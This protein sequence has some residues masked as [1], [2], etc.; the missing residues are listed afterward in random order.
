MLPGTT[1]SS[2]TSSSSP[3]CSPRATLLD[4]VSRDRR[5]RRPRTQQKIEFYTRQFVD[6]MAP[7]QLR[8]DQSRG[9]ARDPREPAART[10]SAASSNM[11]EDLERGNGQLS[12]RMT[13]LDAFEVGHNIATTP[14]KVVYQNELMQLIQYAP[15]HR[16]GAQAAAADRAALDQQVLHPRPAAQEQ[17]HQVRRRPGLHRLRD[18][19]GQ[20]RRGAQPQDLRGL[21]GGGPARGARRHRAGDRRDGRQRDRLLPRRHA[22]GRRRWPIMAA[23]K[24]NRDQGGDLLHHAARL[25]RSGRARRVHR[26][27]AAG[28]VE[29]KMAKR[30][31]LDGARDGRLPST[32]CAPTT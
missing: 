19:L 8:D 1:I 7:S 12:I 17:L 32:C 26:R 22:A 5:P 15:T 3:T 21:H 6:A 28:A 13:D 29:E 10:C 20:S 4:T 24:D 14:G 25:Q 11:L 30:G 31:Y 2:S 27:G 18:L 9:A 23:K 16:D